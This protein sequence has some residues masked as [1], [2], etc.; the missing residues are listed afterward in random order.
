MKA[1]PADPNEVSIFRQVSDLSPALWEDLEARPPQVAA[2][3]AGAEVDDKGVF[4][5]LF[6]GG[7]Y[8]IDPAAK[9]VE[10]PKDHPPADFQKA[11]VLVSY[12]VKA[13]E[14]LGQSGRLVPGRELNGGDMF[15]AGPHTLATKPICD[16]FGFSP[17]DLLERAKFFGAQKDEKAAPSYLSLAWPILPNIS[18]GL[19]F[20]EAD[21]EFEAEATW[22][23]D[24]YSNFH[25]PLD[26]LWALVNIVNN[27]LTA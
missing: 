18:L 16:K 7:I 24:S 3:A 27:D 13:Q 26:C 8:E 4:R 11:M 1:L 15:F 21:D 2:R 12:L 23:F 17:Q 9:T 25:L 14:D 6:M 5:L 20:Y 10:G 19:I 22:L